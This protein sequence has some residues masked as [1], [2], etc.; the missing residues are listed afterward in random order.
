[1]ILTKPFDHGLSPAC[2]PDRVAC[3]LK[4]VTR[5]GAC[6][7]RAAPR[8]ARGVTRAPNPQREISL[9]SW[10]AIDARSSTSISS[11][12]FP[13]PCASS[14]AL[15]RRVREITGLAP[16][17]LIREL[18]LQRGASLLEANAGSI[19]EIAAG[20]GFSSVAYFTKCFRE[21]YG[22]TPGQHR[23]RPTKLSARPS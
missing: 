21:R 19:S 17:D 1:M 8:A 12:R 15:F 16:S 4:R 2:Q 13:K 11:Q 22:R 14:A 10:R 7:G 20:A 6:H 18:R 23:A 3:R 9:R 5:E